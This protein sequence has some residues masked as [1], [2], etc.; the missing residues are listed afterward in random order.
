MPYD[1]V[2]LPEIPPRDRKRKYNL[3]EL[4]IGQ[5]IVIPAGEKYTPSALYSAARTLT[6]MCLLYLP[7]ERASIQYCPKI[8]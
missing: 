7:P 8:D 2:E 4:G 5:A 6:E 1:I 3:D